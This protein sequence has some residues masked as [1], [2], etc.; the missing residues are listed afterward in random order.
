MGESARDLLNTIIT[1]AVKYRLQLMGKDKRAD[2]GC[3]CTNSFHK[4]K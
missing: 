4:E 1:A 2:R 3:E